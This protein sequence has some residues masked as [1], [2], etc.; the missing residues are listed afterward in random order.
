MRKKGI[1]QTASYR[2]INPRGFHHRDPL[3]ESINRAQ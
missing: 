2:P 3:L 1:T